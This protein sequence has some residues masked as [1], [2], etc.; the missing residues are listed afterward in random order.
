MTGAGRRFPVAA[1]GR[2]IGPWTSNC[3]ARWR[4]RRRPRSCFASST[5]SAACRTRKPG[6]QSSRRAAIPNLD[7]LAEDSSCGLTVP[8]GAGVTPGSGPG[9]LALF[10]YD[11][12]K[13]EVGRGV[14]EALGIDFDLKPHRP[15]RTRQLLHRGRRRHDRRPPRRPQSRRRTMVAARRADALKIRRVPGVEVIVEPVREHRFVLVLRGE[16]LDDG[17]TP[18]RPGARRRRAACR[19]GHAGRRPSAPPRSSIE[20]IARVARDAART[21]RSANSVLLR[22]FA[23]YPNLP[24]LPEVTRHAL[25]APSPSTRCTAASPSSSA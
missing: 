10:G 8:V 12:L 17:V 15:R 25:P 3:C 14:L 9:H 1:P 4:P 20:F 16:G 19:A 21:S 22:G 13:Y 24:P 23:K 5:D 18:D 6:A 2:R 11:P 7:R